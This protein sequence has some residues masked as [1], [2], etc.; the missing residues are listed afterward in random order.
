MVSDW[1]PW[2]WVAPVMAAV[3]LVVVVSAPAATRRANRQ[4]ADRDAVMLL[5]RLRLPSGASRTA[6]APGGQPRLWQAGRPAGVRL[7]DDRAWWLVRGTFEDAVAYIRHHVP[8]GSKWSGAGTAS[9]P[10][11]PPNESI[12][13]AWP[14]V[15]GVLGVR[16]LVVTVVGLRNGHTAVGAEAEVQWIIPRPVAEQIPPQATALNV[17][18]GPPGAPPSVTVQT[19]D[20]VK[21]SRIRDMIDRLQIVKPGVINCPA[22]TTSEPLVTFS[23]R[24]APGG[25]VLARATE[26]AQATEPTTACD[27]MDLQIRGHAEDP[28]LGGAAVVHAAQRLLGGVHLTGPPPP[29]PG[30]ARSAPARQT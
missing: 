10:G 13:F 27:P 19:T 7:I 18:V 20:P 29:G 2:R 17:S 14:P 11:I 4:V 23:F 24:A 9:G 1:R 15:S 25:P 28:L 5:A 16:W 8:V 3:A 26:L 30:P 6:T 12:T 22:F 21:V